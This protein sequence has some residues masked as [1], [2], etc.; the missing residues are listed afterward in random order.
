[1]D[2]KLKLLGIKQIREENVKYPQKYSEFRTQ[3][4][5]TLKD[6]ERMTS[7]WLLGDA[8]DNQEYQYL[9]VDSLHLK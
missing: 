3:H 7:L 1:M 5:T 8:H 4:H 2:L 9:Q 6:V